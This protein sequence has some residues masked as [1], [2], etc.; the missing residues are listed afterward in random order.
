LV[1]SVKDW[2]TEWFYASNMEPFLG[3]HSDAGL[4]PNDW[5][6]KM[7]LAIEELKN[8]KPFLDRTRS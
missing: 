6:E 7:P 4:V 8:I 1:N 5:W 2:R 3:V